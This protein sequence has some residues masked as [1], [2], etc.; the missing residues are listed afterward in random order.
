MAFTVS[1]AE[2]DSRWIVNASEDHVTRFVGWYL[3]LSEAEARR[4]IEFARISRKH[5]LEPQPPVVTEAS[6]ADLLA[7]QIN[8]APEV[9][10]EAAKT[11]E[12]LQ[13]VLVSA[14]ADR[15]RLGPRK[16]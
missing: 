1:I 7:S 3:T 4:E 9:S 15:R 8:L 10:I 11:V 2:R 14:T 6:A 12:R 16:R 13:R 5:H